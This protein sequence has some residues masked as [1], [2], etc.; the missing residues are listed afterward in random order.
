[1]PDGPA[2]P[3]GD[4]VPDGLHLHAAGAWGVV[5]TRGDRLFVGPDERSLSERGRVPTDLGT[6]HRLATRAM[7]HRATRSL[8]TGVVGRFVTHTV[9]RIDA[10]HLLATNG[11][12]VLRSIDG[13]RTWERSRRLPRSSP[14]FGVLG[15][16]I[17]SS[18]DEVLVGEYPQR[19]TRPPN[20]LRSTDR[21]ST[22]STIPIQSV[23]HIHAVQV[24][25]YDDAIW[26]TT[27]DADDECRI[28]RLRD[29]DL[30]V[31]GG[32]SQMWRA[33]EL[34]FTPDAI[35]WGMDCGFAEHNPIYKLE[36]DAIGRA[37]PTVVHRLDGSI[38]YSATVELDEGLAIAFSS[39][40]ET[41]SDSWVGSGRDH[42]TDAASVVVSTD[43]SAFR[44]W[45]EVGRFR[46]RRALS[47]HIPGDH[48][49]IA[50][51]YIFLEAH[52]GALLLNPFNTAVKDGRII[53]TEV[54]APRSSGV[55][56]RV[57]SRAGHSR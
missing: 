3:P 55:D 11:R 37:D 41:G 21:G 57:R 53:R 47:A 43:A 30:D 42:S 4:G 7:R 26:I 16:G 39:A 32:G 28:L 12:W 18:G 54:H 19:P 49:P 22:W 2:H 13:G 45:T 27:G 29:G 51:A 1:M 31:A 44:E 33:V 17:C 23:R 52:D 56:G 6:T 5:A 36:R 35:L 20:V 15:S 24:D 48:V 34:A 9:H 46:K 10:D 8:L 50:N 14:P 25:P 38:Y 40:V